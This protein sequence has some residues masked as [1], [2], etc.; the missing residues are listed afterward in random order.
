MQVAHIFLEKIK[1]IREIS[2]KSQQGISSKLIDFI[3]ILPFINV[4]ATKC[5]YH[6]DIFYYGRI[7]LQNLPATV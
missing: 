7:I 5:F 2:D 1:V 4:L 3:N 6:I